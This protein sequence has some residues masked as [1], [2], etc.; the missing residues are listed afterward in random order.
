MTISLKKRESKDVI[1]GNKIV[2]ILLGL[3]GPISHFSYELSQIASLSTKKIDIVL[4]DSKKVLKEDL[5][6]EKFIHADIGL[7]KSEVT[8]QRCSSAFDLNID[9]LEDRKSVV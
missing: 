5:V 6:C 7:S 3:N 8:Q 1:T 2:F 4:V 9:V